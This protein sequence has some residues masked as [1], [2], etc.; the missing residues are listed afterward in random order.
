MT[1][2]NDF[3]RLK[4]HIMAALEY[5]AGTVSL[6]QVEQFLESGQYKLWPG[7]DAVAVTEVCETPNKTFMNIVLGGG[8]LDELREIDK[9]IEYVAR[10]F[11]C[12]GVTIVGRRGWGKVLPNYREYATVYAK[13]F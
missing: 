8:N 5:N 7:K 12:A 3:E 2:K 6:E 1:W 13:E 9:A 4:P 11:G 10:Q